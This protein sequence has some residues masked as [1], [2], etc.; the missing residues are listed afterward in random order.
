VDVDEKGAV[1]KA[2]L[3]GRI[4]KDVLKLQDAALESVTHWRFEPAKQ[5]GRIV[6]CV[7]I[8][9]QIHFQGRPTHLLDF[10]ANQ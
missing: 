7:K 1:T 4:T 2:V 9:V 8:P 5:D 3:G 6:A 10:L